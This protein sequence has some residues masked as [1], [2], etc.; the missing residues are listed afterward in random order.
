LAGCTA[1]PQAPGRITGNVSYKGS[2][3]PAGSVVFH[4]PEQGS[5][6]AQLSADGSYEVRDVPKGKLVVTIET[7][8]VNPAKKPKAY[9]G[10]KGAKMYKE[11]LAA[12]GNSAAEKAP[13]QQYVKIPTKYGVRAKSP[14]SVEVVAGSQ[15][16]NFTLTDD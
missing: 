12:E 15:S 7:E 4:T 2:P 10:E 11:R 16:H 9:G 3:V 14:L 13:P 1:N 8:S 5:Y 6:P